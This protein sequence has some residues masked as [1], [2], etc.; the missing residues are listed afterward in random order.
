VGELHGVDG[1]YVELKNV[2]RTVYQAEDVGK[3]KA[4]A[5]PRRLASQGVMGTL[6]HGHP[7]YCQ[8]FFAARPLYRPT[9]GLVGIDNDRGRTATSLHHQ[10]IGVPLVCVT[11]TSDASGGLVIVQE[12]GEACLGCYFGPVLGNRK[13]PCPG[14]PALLDCCMAVCGFASLAMRS[15]IT[16]SRRT[17]NVLRLDLRSGMTQALRVPRRTGCKLC[18][19]ASR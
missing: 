12:P 1:D 11:L 17:W 7:L 6:I 8:E 5:L 16:K 10:R 15:I 2:T 14:G 18:D 13:E 4:H 19:G 3:P 9:V